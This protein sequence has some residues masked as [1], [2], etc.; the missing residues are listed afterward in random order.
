MAE[1]ELIELNKNE[2]ID[3]LY[4]L[5][6]KK[7]DTQLLS[8]FEDDAQF[9]GPATFRLL[10]ESQLKIF[11]DKIKSTESTR[12]LYD[13]L[14]NESYINLYGSTMLISLLTQYNSEFVYVKENK[15][16]SKI[17]EY[18]D[19]IKKYKKLL[20]LVDS[21]SL[22]SEMSI[23]DVKKFGIGPINPSDELQTKIVKMYPN[24]FINGQYNRT[25]YNFYFRYLYETIEYRLTKMYFY[26]SLYKFVKENWENFKDVK[27]DEKFRNRVY[28]YY[29]KEL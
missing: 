22:N 18:K 6:N 15:L 16:D 29:T 19:L 14:L 23:R 20:E 9:N 8:L 4:I 1:Q 2:G 7:N 25:I 21:L 13:F 5:M 12:K 24:L 28:K 11:F 10:P 3:N 27:D 17:L 26:H